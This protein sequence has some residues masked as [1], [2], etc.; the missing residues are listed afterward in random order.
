MRK[1]NINYLI[2]PI[3]FI[4][5]TLIYTTNVKT[6]LSDSDIDA[7]E[8][9][10]VGKTCNNLL[11]FDDEINCVVSIQN[12][13][14]EI[15]PY[16][17]DFSH[18]KCLYDN[19]EIRENLF[20][21]NYEPEIYIEYQAGCC[22]LRSRYLE[23]ALIYYGFNIRHLGIFR[24][25]N[26]IEVLT[27]R[28]IISHSSTEVKTSKGWMYVDSVDRFIAITIDGK[29]VVAEN[30]KNIDKE[31]LKYKFTPDPKSE[32]FKS[33]QN[34]FD[35]WNLNH[36]IWN[37]E[38]KTYIIYGLHSRHGNFYKPKFKIDI[39]DINWSN[40]LYNFI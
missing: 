18:L 28:T 24:A 23:K 36:N 21:I 9:L 4:V 10:N 31:K 19:A 34:N 16:K 40:F 8:Q 17:E 33:F 5:C 29:P 15:I 7:I 12:A 3:I 37:P 14:Y 26:F 2:L 39:P 1:L 32:L 22:V 13:I 11:G 6:K 20:D 30:Y 35:E 38:F 27:S 25:N